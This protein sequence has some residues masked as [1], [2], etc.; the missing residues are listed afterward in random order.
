M[1]YR[2]AVNF[3]TLSTNRYLDPGPGPP[4]Q[5]CIRAM[6]ILYSLFHFILLLFSLS[7]IHFSFWYT[8]IALSLLICY[9]RTSFFLYL[10]FKMYFSFFL[11][12]F[13]YIFFSPTLGIIGFQVDF[14]PNKLF[15][16]H[17]SREKVRFGLR[18]WFTQ[19]HIEFTTI[20]RIILLLPFSKNIERKLQ[21]LILIFRP[22]PDLFSV[23]FFELLTRFGNPALN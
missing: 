1:Q 8:S 16:G 15:T 23:P 9:F 10:S 12:L 14:Q 21:F 4:V 18:R 22:D 2:F 3:G 20:E 13:I 7:S 19:N 11:F 6:I 5:L 17:N